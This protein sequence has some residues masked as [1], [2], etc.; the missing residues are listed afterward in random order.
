[1]NIS[2]TTTFPTTPTFPGGNQ[3]TVTGLTGS[4][5]KNN[6]LTALTARQTTQNQ[7]AQVLTDA[8]NAINT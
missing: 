6:L 4:D 8:V 7:G 1:M 5:L 2:Q 3:V